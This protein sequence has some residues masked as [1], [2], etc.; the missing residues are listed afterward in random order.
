MNGSELASPLQGHINDYGNYMAPEG[1]LSKRELFAAMAL[2]GMLCYCGFRPEG[3]E[4]PR[5]ASAVRM[6]D[7]LIKELNK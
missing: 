6:A 1:G 4:Q 3:D 2:Q 5:A 7:A